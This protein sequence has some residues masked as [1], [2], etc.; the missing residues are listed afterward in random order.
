VV[1]HK[2]LKIKLSW[3]WFEPSSNRRFNGHYRYHRPLF[4]HVLLWE[5]GNITQS[6]TILK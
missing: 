1:G 4:I 5:I 6:K 3:F 2:S